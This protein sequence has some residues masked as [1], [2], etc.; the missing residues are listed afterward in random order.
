MSDGRSARGQRTHD[1]VVAALIGL[2]EEDD[3]QPS[4]EAIAER[5][6][7]STRSIFSHFGD[8]ESLLE[9]VAARR[10]E[11]I[12]GAWGEL[13]S[14]DAPLA[15]RLDAFV[16]QRARIYELIGSV[17]RAALLTEPSSPVAAERVGSFRALKRRDAL[18]MFAT[19]VAGNPARAAA[20]GAVASFSTWDELRRHQQLGV[21]DA[22]AALHAAL[23]AL[24]TAAGPGTSGMGD[25]L[26]HDTP[27]RTLTG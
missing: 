15:E 8:R 4:I 24:L 7:V 6:G 18:R 1:A 21:E 14:P 26:V 20:L 19:E 5:A 9:A 23:A 2:L 11:S 10:A 16:A 25:G 3:L 13:P 12:R 27:G 17:R 22:A